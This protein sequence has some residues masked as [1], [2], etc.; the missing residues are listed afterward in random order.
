MARTARK[1]LGYRA[2]TALINAVAL[3]SPRRGRSML[4]FRAMRDNSEYM[5]DIVRSYS[6]RGAQSQQGSTPW[7]GGGGSAD[8]E[9]QYDL[10]TLRNRIRELN[11][12]D[13]IAC[14]LTHTFVTNVIGSEIRP[15]ANTGD[16]EKNRRIEAYWKTR[17]PGLAPAEAATFGELQRLLFRKYVEDG[18]V[19]L[20]A[21]KTSADN[22]VWFEVIEADRVA[23]PPGK[24]GD[25]NITDGVEKDAYGIPVAYWV[26]K[27]HPGDN[28]VKGLQ[29]AREFIRVPAQSIRHFKTT[30]RPGQTRGVP[31]FHAI[32][33]DLRD[34]DLL[35]VASL[36]R[37]QIAACLAVFFE[38]PE[39]VENLAG[40][41]TDTTTDYGSMLKD[42]LRPGM[43]WKN[44]PGEKVNTLVPNF[45]TP[46]FVPFVTMLCRK[47][48]ASVGVSW[49]VVLKDFGDS[50]FTSS[51]TDLLETRATYLW[52]QRMFCD[53]LLDW[54]W[55]TVMADA[56]FTGDPAM[57][58]IN[59]A[60][61]PAVRWVPPGWKWTDASKEAK[62]AQLE[63]DIGKTTVRDLCAE[64]GKDWEEVFEQRVLEMDMYAKA[65]AGIRDKYGVDLIGKSVPPEP[66]PPDNADDNA[67]Q[68]GKSN[69]E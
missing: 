14:G 68:E 21:T 39:T 63:L 58:G 66:E 53:V 51:K 9:I 52:Q 59:L 1:S 36:K 40:I 67:D 13:T 48:G 37:V 34:L 57:A 60:S 27:G 26:S 24:T 29:A 69:A 31:M 41:D 12:D 25:A 65:I 35:L 64:E 23:T 33:Q 32:I 10:P 30:E 54:I 56:V 7:L 28:N 43:M 45:P 55:H 15:Q 61:L 44:N 38:T 46:E 11:R 20:K 19:F 42:S 2:E 49:Q 22:P 17:A 50:T 47:I 3:V 6:Y 4:H 18:E 8:T 16:P 62:G 5:R